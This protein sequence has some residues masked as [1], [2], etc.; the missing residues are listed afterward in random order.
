MSAK[1]PVVEKGQG[2]RFVM[3][4]I[5]HIEIVG[6]DGGKLKSF[7]SQ[8]FDWSITRKDV[9][10]FDYYDIELGDKPTVGIRHEPDGKAELVFYVEVDDLDQSVEKAKELGASVRIPPKR[11]GDLRFALIEDPEGNP[12]GL[13]QASKG[14]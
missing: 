9:A 12:I 14:E 13:T 7:Y 1:L 11:S 6:T 2:E 3:A 5:K 8:L 10:G 4:S